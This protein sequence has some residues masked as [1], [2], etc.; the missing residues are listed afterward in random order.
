VEGVEEKSLRLKPEGIQ[1][2]QM[3]FQST[4]CV[5]QEKSNQKN[6]IYKTL[7]GK[8]EVTLSG[9]LRVLIMR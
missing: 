5:I 8:G 2:I 3:R 7:L 9:T 6:S 1:G 4:L